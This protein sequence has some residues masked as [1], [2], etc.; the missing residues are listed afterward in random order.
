MANRV[1]P[2]K[3][4][5]VAKSK[6]KNIPDAIYEAINQL[7]TEDFNGH[8]ATVM[9]KEVVKLLKKKGLNID[10]VFRRG[11]LD[12]EDAYRSAGW[13]VEYDKPAYCETYEAY[14]VFSLSGK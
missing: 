5:E 14:F 7:I 1:S 8:S 4:K 10:E 2:L 12:V 6:A 13:K 11:W 3:A 9:Q